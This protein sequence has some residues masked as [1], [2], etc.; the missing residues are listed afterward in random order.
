MAKEFKG[1]GYVSG[2]LFLDSPPEGPGKFGP[3]VREILLTSS[4]F[5]WS[6]ISP[7]VFGAML[8]GVM[9]KGQRREIGAHYTSE[10]NILKV[11]GPLFLDELWE[12]FKALKAGPEGLKRFHEKI[13]R[14]KFLD[15]ACGCGN[16]LIVTYRELRFLEL[17]ILKVLSFEKPPPLDSPP[18][19]KVSLERFYGIEI[20]DFPCQI[21]QIGLRLTDLQ[22]DLEF[23][24]R[25]G[26]NFVRFPVN[27][28]ANIQRANAL[29]LDWER[30]VAKEELSYILGNP[31]FLGYS[32]Q[33]QGQKADISLVF[34]NPHG[35]PYPGA[36]KI[37]YVAAW[38]FKAAK[39]MA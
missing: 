31:P 13:S 20:E 35:K 1:F 30:V 15:P 7:A 19:P 28:S 5:D 23:S 4:A 32:N 11:I 6:A 2:G 9:E 8:Q 16:F 37:D 3:K 18:G 36:G 14:L 39:F 26:K 38:Y 25:L 10:G 29:G 27:P 17:E 33:S 21:A 12:E 22:M 24:K 34:T